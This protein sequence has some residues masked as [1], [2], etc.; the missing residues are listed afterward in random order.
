VIDELRK[1][2]VPATDGHVLRHGGEVGLGG[3]AVIELGPDPATRLV[4][5]ALE[6]LQHDERGRPLGR[7]GDSALHDGHLR[8][9][10]C[11]GRAGR[12][13]VKAVALEMHRQE[14]NRLAVMRQI[15]AGA[16]TL[17]AITPNIERLKVR[18]AR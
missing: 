13:V 5:A 9:E 7:R 8:R 18:L 4:E 16:I 10:R 2:V 12:R 17:G 3:L 14:L 15:D 1:F 6:V 11:T